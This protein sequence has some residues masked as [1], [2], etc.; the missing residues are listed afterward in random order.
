M[1]GDFFHVQK[2]QLKADCAVLADPFPERF[3]VGAIV[4][5]DRLKSLSASCIMN[6]M[7]P[8]GEKMKTEEEKM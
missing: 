7:P 8:A 6:A 5:F 4:L 2:C 1:P 3:L